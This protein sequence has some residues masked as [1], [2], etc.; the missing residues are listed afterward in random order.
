MRGR[1]CSLYGKRTGSDCA[2]LSTSSGVHLHPEL[3]VPA[4]LHPPA[5]CAK[6]TEQKAQKVKNWKCM[7]CTG[8]I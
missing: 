5:R 7:G 6:M 1:I 8:E 4:L 3:S 2:K